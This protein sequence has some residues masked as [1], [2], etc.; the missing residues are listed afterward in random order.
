MS[1]SSTLIISFHEH[2]L[3]PKEIWNLPICVTLLI[4]E[5][6][7]DNILVDTGASV[8]VAPISTLHPCGIK[9]AELS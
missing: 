6:A 8:C 1:L 7:I 4:C 9:V 2:E 5:I 3:A